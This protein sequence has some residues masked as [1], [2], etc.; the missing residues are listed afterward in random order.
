MTDPKLVVRHSELADGPIVRDGEWTMRFTLPR[1][2]GFDFH[3]LREVARG[4]IEGDLGLRV[5][6]NAGV[7]LDMALAGSFRQVVSLDAEQR[8]RLQVIKRNADGIR[9]GAGV[10]AGVRMETPLP[11]GADELTAAILGAHRAQAAAGYAQILAPGALPSVLGLR[12]EI[13]R[14]AMEA[15]GRRYTVEATVQFERTEEGASLFDCSFAFS[16]E[17]LRLYRAALDGDF[18]EILTRESRDVQ[19]REAA[20]ARALR[21]RTHIEL[22]LPFFDRKQWEARVEAFAAMHVESD[23]SG[24]LLVYHAGGTGTL[25]L[26][27]AYQSTLALAGGLSVGRV[28]SEANFTLS[29][30]DRRRMPTASAASRLEDVLSAYEFES[31]AAEWLARM[32]E[33]RTGAELEST[34]T[35]SVPGEVVSAW[36]GAPDERS[37]VYFRTYA[38]V[39]RAVQRAMRRWLPL[40]YFREAERYEA[41]G[42][43]FPLLVY[44]CSKIYECRPKHDFS[45]DVMSREWRE[46]FFSRAEKRLRKELPRVH[47]LLETEG[48]KRAAR[49][50]SPRQAE[51]IA[52]S[53]ARSPRLLIS[54]LWADALFVD[55]L[56]TLGCRAGTLRAV[57]AKDP[58]RAVRQLTDF[59]SELVKAFHSRLRR[60]YGGEDFVALGSL[61]L[62]EATNALRTE[63]RETTAIRGT[64]TVKADG[65][66]RTF[67]NAAWR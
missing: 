33:E 26:K 58:Q 57:M 53:V 52:V 8:L 63:F 41:L 17:G 45:Y 19:V 4:A 10:T 2:F 56:I 25:V 6:A 35:L 28:H 12:D 16:E 55:S 48:R 37:D 13:Y 44:Q 5:D 21:E 61:L 32:G 7:A 18:S 42:A 30:T 49:Y 67:V 1:R 62:V 46:E 14:R 50:Y 51:D 27:N 65:V 43:A 60:L 64:L 22:H 9:L 23:D 11:E 59:S 54:L 38:R 31:G 36:L 15:L 24:R 39:S 40:V 66:E 47:R 29:Y 3:W 20:V 34:L